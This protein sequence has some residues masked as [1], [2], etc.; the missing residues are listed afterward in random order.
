MWNEPLPKGLAFDEPVRLSV[1]CDLLPDGSFGRELLVVT[2]QKVRVITVGDG[3]GGSATQKR[4]TASRGRLIPRRVDTPPTTDTPPTKVRLEL[5]FAELKEP[6]AESFFGGG[7]LEV[8]HNGARIEL[9]RYT[10]ARFPRFATA[11][12]M[13]EKWLKGETAE[14]PPDDGQRCPTCGLPLDKGTKVCPVCVSKTRSLRRL[15]ACL[16]PYLL[17]AVTLAFLASLVTAVGL[18]I[19]YLQKPVIDNVLSEKS[20]L[21]LLERGGLLT[22]IVLIGLG[23]YVVSSAA[24]IAQ[25]WLSAWVGNRITHDIRCQLYSHLQYL[26]L[27]FYDKAEMGTIISRVNQDTGQLQAFLVWGSQDLVINVLQIVGIGVVLFLMN[28]KLALFILVPAPVVMLLSGIFWKHIHHHIHRMFHRWG[29]LNALLSETL[30]G[31][32]VVKAFS[33]EAREVRR[34]N[35]RSEELATTG[36]FVERIWATL[37]SG[38]GLLIALGTLLVWYLG[39]RDVL[40]NTMTVGGLVVFVSLAA[41]FYQPLRWMS[42]L[43]NWCSRS[44]TAA[45]RVFE[46]LDTRPEV[47]DPESAVPMPHI[48]GRVEY[49][50]V[51]FGYEPHR[52]VLKNVSFEAKPGE[53]IGLV[54]QSGAGKTTTINLLCRFYN[55]DEGDILIDG[56]SIRSIRVEDLR[57]QLGVVPQDTFLFGGTILENIAYA[58]SD[59]TKEEIVRAAKIANAHD[60]I[61]RK[62]DGYE[63]WLGE[64]GGGLSA[65]ERQRLA[66]ARAV[67]HDP[68]I[69]ILDEATSQ[70]DV[71]TEKQVQEAIARLVKGR[72]TFAIAHRLATLRNADR[73][74]VLKNG[75]IT[76]TGTHDELLAKEGGEFN[77]LVK[78][79][80]EISKVR[81]IER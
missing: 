77:R 42:Q 44:L 13:M 68:R 31:L 38:I 16:R 58:K 79:Y 39:A 21:S 3:V 55:P 57:H 9:V 6:K 22:L 40:G 75:E 33:Q 65:G 78:T 26:S 4:G 72:T 19:P 49:K 18:V 45:E 29:R 51:T 63:T 2:A 48:E 69:L 10:S 36:V 74:V 46:V 1:E 11:A 70:L 56:L 81:A 41:M 32:R 34:F 14:V 7:A 76:E 47:E 20:P 66:I 37:F 17:H 67:L 60:F 59:A 23:A 52:P 24:G 71:Q 15:L 43:L 64:K 25:A 62:A 61:L 30:N 28:W 8:S 50:G 5:P 12:K 53:M 27:S 80:Q 35:I 73:L 54:G